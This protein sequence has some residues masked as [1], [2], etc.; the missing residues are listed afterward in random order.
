MITAEMARIDRIMLT[1][2]KQKV[3]KPSDL[4]ALKNLGE[5]FK[6]LDEDRVRI[7]GELRVAIKE[8]AAMFERKEKVRSKR[9]AVE[10]KLT[11]IRN[12]TSLKIPD[13]AKG[14]ISRRIVKNT[15]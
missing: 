6:E 15:F 5:Q 10:D 9:K 7:G 13:T 3:K 4:K 12:S 11:Q 1:S 14:G 2:Q 8:A